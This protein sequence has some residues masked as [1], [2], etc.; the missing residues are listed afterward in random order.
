MS[1]HFPHALREG[2]SELNT[3]QA[4]PSRRLPAS[5][6]LAD[7][8]WAPCSWTV[9][10]AT[11]PRMSVLAALMLTSGQTHTPAPHT[12]AQFGSL[13]W[14]GSSPWPHCSET[15]QPLDCLPL[16]PALSM[17]ED[18][19]SFLCSNFPCG[20]GF[21]TAQ[22]SGGAVTGHPQTFHQTV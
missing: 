6:D 10:K 8:S 1:S 3:E 17:F 2:S 21:T 12:S 11:C 18:T 19:T 13:L 9:C 14:L 4:V 20:P 22:T 7:S 5:S 15:S 16:L